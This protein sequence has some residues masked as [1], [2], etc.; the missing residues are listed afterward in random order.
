MK[1]FHNIF[2][3]LFGGK[4][5]TAVHV[6]VSEQKGKEIYNSYPRPR[7]ISFFSFLTI[8]MAHAKNSCISHTPFTSF[9][10]NYIKKVFIKWNEFFFCSLCFFYFYPLIS[11]CTLLRLQE[12][13]GIAIFLSFLSLY[14]FYTHRIFYRPK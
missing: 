3:F 13:A 7:Y 6:M 14:I 4:S 11:L 1:N 12:M 2:Q 9:C 5:L 8:S 10:C